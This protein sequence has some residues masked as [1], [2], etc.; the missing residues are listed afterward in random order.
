[1][2]GW[3]NNNDNHNDNH[4]D[5]DIFDNSSNKRQLSPSVLLPLPTQPIN[6]AHH[7]LLRP[8]LCLVFPL[9]RPSHQPKHNRN[10][11]T[12]LPSTSTPPTTTTK[13]TRG[14]GKLAQGTPP[15]PPPLHF[16]NTNGGT[17]QK[18]T[19]SSLAPLGS[20]TPVQ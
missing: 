20:S 8:A 5:D 13:T 11:H 7:A 19:S 2:G 17:P 12:R 1:M 14:T 18:K 4:N 9:V 6:L 16:D 3:T 15:P 10:Q